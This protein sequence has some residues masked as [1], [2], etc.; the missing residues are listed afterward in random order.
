MRIAAAGA[1]IIY[2]VAPVELYSVHSP[3]CYMAVRHRYT[4]R[5]TLKA[6]NFHQRQSPR[7]HPP[8]FAEQEQIPVSSFTPALGASGC[9][10][11]SATISGLYIFSDRWQTRL[12]DHTWWPSQFSQLLPPAPGKID[13][14]VGHNVKLKCSVTG[15]PE[16]TVTWYKDGLELREGS[17]GGESRLNRHSLHLLDLRPEDAGTYTCAAVNDLGARNANWTLRVID[18]ARPKEPEFNP[19]YPANTTVVAGESATFQCSGNSDVTPHIKWLRRL[20]DGSNE[21]EHIPDKDTL[22]WKGHRY[23]VLQA[24]QVH[25][26]SDGSF[27]TK[28]VIPHV[29]VQDTGVYVCTATSNFGL[30]YRQ[31]L[32]SVI[33][34]YIF[35]NTLIY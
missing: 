33:G 8:E 14:P 1:E 32:L 22:N 4:Y 2:K 28:L 11:Y 13:K 25:T 6:Q 16:P 20:E 12:I 5:S 21:A 34:A 23:I 26:P 9:T 30:A 10:G 15:K 31:A 29:S 18:Q 3:P 17:L 24:T 27:Y 7:S 35:N 19:L